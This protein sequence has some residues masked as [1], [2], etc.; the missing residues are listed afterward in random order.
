[1]NG[2]H[3]DRWRALD[4]EISDADLT[5]AINRYNTAVI[6]VKRCRQRLDDAEYAEVEAGAD[7]AQEIDNVWESLDARTRKQLDPKGAL[8]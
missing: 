6:E 5:E 2:R 4:G 1:M 8:G 3:E 7:L